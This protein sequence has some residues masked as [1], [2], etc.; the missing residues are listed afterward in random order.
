MTLVKWLIVSYLFIGTDFGITKSV[1]NKQKGKMEIIF[2]VTHL[3]M[4]ICLIGI[5]HAFGSKEMPSRYLE[6]GNFGVPAKRLNNRI[7]VRNMFLALSISVI[8]VLAKD[9]QQS[10]H[11]LK[12]QPI[13][14]IIK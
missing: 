4:A 10:H 3:V 12:I 11:H 14:R 9:Y 1:P 7:L 5:L 2:I 6:A 13:K 8:Y